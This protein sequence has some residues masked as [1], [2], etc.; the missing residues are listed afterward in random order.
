M[1]T[2]NGYYLTAEVVPHI[3]RYVE[4][5][6]E[7]RPS[8]PKNGHTSGTGFFS[9]REWLAMESGLSIGTVRQVLQQRRRT[10]RG[11]TADALLTAVGRPD[12]LQWLTEVDH[13]G[14]VKGSTTDMDRPEGG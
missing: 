7:V 13:Y 11:R 9:G 10:I 3:M 1:I 8:Q 6:D 12:L 4:R 5:H 14:K 2:T